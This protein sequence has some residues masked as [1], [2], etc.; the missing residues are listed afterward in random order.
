MVL[1]VVAFATVFVV[2]GGF[3][4]AD[5]TNFALIGLAAREPPRSVW[6][7]AASAFV[8]TTVLSVAIGAALLE[9]LGGQVLYLRLGG[10]VLLL[11]YAAYLAVVPEKRETVRAARSAGLTAFVLILLL[12]L[13][14]TTMILTMNFVFSLRDVVLVGVAAGLALVT[15]AAS[16]CF[17]GSRL[18]TRIDP[19][20]LERWVIVVLAVVGVATI[21]YALYPGLFPVL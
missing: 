10:G 2:I 18:G 7:G 13:G 1:S 12:E 4:L 9:L 20:R 21:V 19:R 6:V 14:D 5:R 16:A 17:I 11:A 3:E 15:V 8:V